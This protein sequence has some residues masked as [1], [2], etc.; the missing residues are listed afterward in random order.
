MSM[1]HDGLQ[2]VVN[3]GDSHR[4]TR[5]FNRHMDISETERVGTCYQDSI[6]SI[7]SIYTAVPDHRLSD[8]SLNLSLG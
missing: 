6:C 4:A 7:V 8:V 2:V 1:F 5:A 3:N